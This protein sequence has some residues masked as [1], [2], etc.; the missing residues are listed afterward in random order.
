MKEY[1][2]DHLDQLIQDVRE[3]PNLYLFIVAFFIIAL[4]WIIW[5]SCNQLII[6][7]F[8][9]KNT[10]EE[11]GQWGDSFGGFNAFFGA[12]GTILVAVT[13][14]AQT[15]ANKEQRRQI[16]IERFEETFFRL[17]DYMKELKLELRYEQTPSFKSIRQDY[18]ID[19]VLRGQDAIFEAYKE[20]NFWTFKNNVG[21]RYFK[22]GNVAHNY[23]N[24][25]HHRFEHCFAPYFRIIYTILF[26]IKNDKVLSE[27]EKAYYG[28][29]LRAQLGSY[30]TGLLAFNAT[31]RY[32]KDLRELLIYFRMLKYI[33]KKRRR[34][35][36]SIFPPEAYAPRPD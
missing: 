14:A 7:I 28:N 5:S 20:V 12:F 23:D 21:V 1:K 11:A 17:I 3:R 2:V 32:S 25:V 29:I 6:E 19:G 34:V 27:N 15:Q 4:L 9:G 30:E 26:K 33:P 10:A 24:Y 13:L 18:A 16:H 8:K 35:L 22:R 31:S 36:G